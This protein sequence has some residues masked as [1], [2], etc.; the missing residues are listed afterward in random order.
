MYKS[1]KPNSKEKGITLIALII[2]IIILLILA[3][4]TIN[5][6]IGDN[7]L[8]KTAKEAGEKYEKAAA[9]EK[10]EAVL[11]LL[12]A[13]K[14][15]NPEY[16]NQEYIDN[17]LG[18]NDIQIEG[19][20]VTVDGWQFEINRDTLKIEKEFDKLN[21]KEMLKPQIRKIEKE[22]SKN[23]VK[24][25]IELKNPEEVTIV[26]SIKKYG[27]DQEKERTAS[28]TECEYTFENLE[29]DE[30]YI[31]LVEATN[32][33]GASTKQILLKLPSILV[34]KI[35][36][37]KEALELL[38]GSTES[39]IATVLPEDASNKTVS[40][41]SDNINVVTVN[42][43]T[44]ELTGA[45]E[46]TANVMAKATDGSGIIATCRVRVKKPL[47]ADVVNVGDFVNYS[48]GNWT[49]EDI[50]K[51]GDL[52]S[53]TSLPSSNGKFGGFE[54]AISKDSSITPYGT[55]KNFYDGWRVFSKNSDGTINIMHA[56]TPEGFY[57]SGGNNRNTLENVR[58]WSMYEDCSTDS[59]STEFAVKG[60]AHCMTNTEAT[61]IDIGIRRTGAYYWTAGGNGTGRNHYCFSRWKYV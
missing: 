46:G 18:E 40:W 17:K 5:V 58:D 28:M 20:I 31:I 61:S 47:L 44:G 2:T 8:F 37:N 13:E 30:S 15:T 41:T 39:L 48:L 23:K 35:E 4:V 50:R 3:G 38:M 57:N 6:L 42:S 34:S 51:I 53:G 9:R 7:G 16:N 52:Y 19:N 24:I 49:D 14:L 25:K 21:E 26:Y 11:M 27:E 55:D 56:G 54:T 60:S 45:G 12:Q 59:V 1:K 32:K 29:Q 22:I 33:Y 43:A 36:L 10:L